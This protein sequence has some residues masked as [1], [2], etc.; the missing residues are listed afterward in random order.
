MGHTVH[1]AATAA[2]SS[3]Q[4]TAPPSTRTAAHSHPAASGSHAAASHTVAANRQ[5]K[6]QRE[7]G[8]Y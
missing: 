8:P 7:A 4:R 2:G 6:S 1:T 5:K 3:Q